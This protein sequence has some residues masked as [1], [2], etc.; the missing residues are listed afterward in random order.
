MDEH[1]G[2]FAVFSTDDLEIIE[3]AAGDPTSVGRDPADLT[4]DQAILALQRYG[5]MT[6]W[7]AGERHDVFRLVQRVGAS[8]S[9]T[10]HGSQ[11]LMVASL[12]A[13]VAAAQQRLRDQAQEHAELVPALRRQIASL[14]RQLAG[15]VCAMPAL[16]L[17]VDEPPNEWLLID[18]TTRESISGK[19]GDGRWLL[20]REL[21]ALRKQTVL[22]IA[23]DTYEGTHDDD[24]ATGD[25]DYG[26]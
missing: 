4:L 9:A 25:L 6:D 14:E 16:N 24:D 11:E 21:V 3:T 26:D 23:H 7:S 17:P 13:E 10:E 1:G 15:S 20:A 22:L 2:G 8:Q 12:R 18:S 5:Q 19:H